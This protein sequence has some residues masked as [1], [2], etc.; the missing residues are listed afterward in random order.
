MDRTWIPFMHLR[1][2]IK[3]QLEGIDGVKDLYVEPITGGKYIDITIKREEIGR[4]GLS[5][6]DVNTIVERRLG[7]MKLTTTIEGRQRF[8]VN[9]RYGQDF[10][11]NLECIKKTAG[12]DD[13]FRSCSFGS[14]S[15]Y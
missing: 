1:K 13:E 10:R 15:R 7:G 11:N 3:K 12:A 14:R 9:A 8:S 6:D 5:V 2:Q 4:Y